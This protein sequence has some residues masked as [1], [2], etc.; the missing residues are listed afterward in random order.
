ML[1]KY[2]NTRMI[3]SKSSS[4][5]S[6]L[7]TTFATQG[8]EFI[9]LYIQSMDAHG[10]SPL[11]NS[12]RPIETLHITIDLKKN[13]LVHGHLLYDDNLWFKKTFN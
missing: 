10:Y 11:F 6:V 1:Q 3:R 8:R 13:Q 7:K 4:A 5:K 9:F 2:Q 12:Y